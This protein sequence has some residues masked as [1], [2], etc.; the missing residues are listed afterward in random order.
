MQLQ[1]G[2]RVANHMLIILRIMASVKSPLALAIFAVD[3]ARL[4]SGF[5]FAHN[6]YAGLYL[7]FV[8]GG[9]K[10]H[11]A[12]YPLVMILCKHTWHHI[13][14]GRK[15]KQRKKIVCLVILPGSRYIDIAE[16]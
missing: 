1:I 8:K 13:P 10:A 16:A 12:F 4:I 14:F 9:G 15:I 7:A 5:H 11:E 2:G 6:N 3:I